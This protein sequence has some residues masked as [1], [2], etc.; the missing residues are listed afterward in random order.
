MTL[1]GIGHMLAVVVTAVAAVERI[2]L[3]A[4]VGAVGLVAE[5]V[6]QKSNRNWVVDSF[7]SSPFFRFDFVLAVLLA[8]M[9]LLSH[10]INVQVN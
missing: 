7:S 4:V 6:A 3:V 10:S 1:A 8:V 5:L 2:A 9:I